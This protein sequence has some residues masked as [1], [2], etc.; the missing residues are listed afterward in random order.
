MVADYVI[1][2]AG[3]AGC[4]LA[5][6]LSEDP[7]V[8]VLLLEAGGP[9]S[10]AELHI[11]AAFPAVFKSSLDWDIFGEEEPGLGGRRLYLPRGRVIGGSGSINAMIYL[12]GHRADFDDWAAKGCK[13]WSYDEVLPYFKRAEDN[14]R[15]SDEFHGVGG[16]LSVS[17]SR[18][19]QPLIEVML[20]A[21]VQAGYEHIPD[22]NVDRPE[23][24]SRFQLTQRG[25]F[26]CSTADAYLN[27]ALERD[28]LQVVSGAFVQRIAFEGDRAVG[29]EVVRDGTVETI[30]AEREVILSAGSY[31]S[32]VLLMLSGIGPAAE[33]GRLGI[34]VREELPVGRNLQDHFMAQLNYTTDEPT[35][36]GTFT[37]ENFAQLNDEG[38]GPLTSNIPEAGGFFRT[39]EELEAPDVEFHFAPSMFF[40]Q[41]LTAPSEG[42]YCFGPVVIKPTSRGRV[43]LRAPLPDS[44]P[45]VLCNFLTTEE[46]RRTL[47]EGVRIALEI[48]A[49]PALK[50]V[51]R[52]PFSVPSSTSDEDILAWAQ[53]AGQSVYHPTSTCAMGEVVD[54]ELR[55]F[56][57]DGLRVVDAS[58]MPTVTR[59]NTNAATIM[60]AEK[61][62]DL[63]RAHTPN[64]TATMKGA[65]S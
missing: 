37:P 2:G 13:G 32:P 9:D 22:L 57:I 12:R 45:R 38:R 20:E 36:F 35:L 29:V 16:P 65:S 34:T 4:V 49:Q 59:A 8:K 63:I 41:G 28:N 15:G 54:H 11:P 51:E 7:D 55:V 62:A 1:V 44:K 64:Q 30:R 31:Q 60:I 21:A 17:D 5:G 61:A 42:G 24:V 6:R 39:R 25:G 33:L 19:M 56:G 46:D 53:T 48:A 3:S 14:D 10:I 50:A 23:G 40:D 18:S 58:V 27:P 26:R 47:V 43:M 52:E